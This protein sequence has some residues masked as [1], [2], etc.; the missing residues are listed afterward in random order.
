VAGFNG[1]DCSRSDRKDARKAVHLD[2]GLVIRYVQV[3]WIRNLEV[4]VE[5]RSITLKQGTV[6]SA[7]ESAWSW[8]QVPGWRAQRQLQKPP[9]ASCRWVTASPRSPEMAV[10]T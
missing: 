4:L 6:R 3:S 8:G 5:V 9:V 1:R 10:P 2:D 7:P